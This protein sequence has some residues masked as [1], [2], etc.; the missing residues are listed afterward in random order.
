MEDSVMEDAVLDEAA[1][2]QGPVAGASADEKVADKRAAETTLADDRVSVSSADQG[3][4][5]P[6]RMLVRMSD[7]AACSRVERRFA[8]VRR[9]LA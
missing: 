7:R 5:M 6:R 4:P 8:G 3:R 1:K 2:D 9:S